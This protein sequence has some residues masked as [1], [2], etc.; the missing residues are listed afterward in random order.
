MSQDD[1]RKLLDTYLS[2]NCTAAEKQQVERWFAEAGRGSGQWDMMGAEAK[3]IYLQRLYADIL[4]KAHASDKAAGATKPVSLSRRRR[5]LIPWLAAASFT[6]IAVGAAVLLS[7]HPGRQGGDRPA[8]VSVSTKAGEL[9]QLTLPDGTRVWLNAAASLRYPRAFSATSREIF[10]EGE[11]FFDVTKNEKKPFIVHTGKVEAR[12]LGTCFNVSG[13][14][15]DDRVVI[16]VVSG[17]VEVGSRLEG[18][19]SKIILTKDQVAAYQKSSGRM[20]REEGASAADYAGW[21]NGVLAFRHTP[22]KEVVQDLYRR[23]G[24]TFTF[25]NEAINR[26]E[27]SGHFNV[28]EPAAEVIK[29]ICLSIGARYQITGKQVIISGPGCR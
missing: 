29:A 20:T 10:L 22:V 28:K 3:K 15:S 8:Y 7:K 18:A 23:Y 17:K 5:R 27:I 1:V 14:A 26:C 19:S 16:A 2:G 21:R 13:Y 11:A 24:L 25:K 12:V 4:H 9:R 6:V